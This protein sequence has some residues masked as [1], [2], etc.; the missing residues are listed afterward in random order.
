M[1]YNLHHTL[2]ARYVGISI[3]TRPNNAGGISIIKKANN[4]HPLLAH[5]FSSS[6]VLFASFSPRITHYVGGGA[7]SGRCRS[8]W[9]TNDYWETSS[10]HK[11]HS[12]NCFAY[13]VRVPVVGL[14]RLGF[15]RRAR[16]I[17]ITRY[18]PGRR[19][20]AVHS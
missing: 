5:A 20:C 18:R 15:L 4:D 1:N 9:L 2:H 6:P 17:I 11:S 7:Q 16:S 10:I 8:R 3:I 19:G 12:R 13:L 14:L